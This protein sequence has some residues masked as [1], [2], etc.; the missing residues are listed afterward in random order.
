[1]K[2]HPLILTLTI[3]IPL[4]LQKISVDDDAI[5]LSMVLNE[6]NCDETIAPKPHKIP[7][8]NLTEPKYAKGQQS[9]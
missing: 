8:N 6:F 1:M 9:N 4:H 5:M 2:I 7:I 3:L